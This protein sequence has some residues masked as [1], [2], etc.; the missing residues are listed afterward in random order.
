VIEGAFA[1]VVATLSFLVAM[2]IPLFAL[3]WRTLLIVIAVGAAFFA[4]LTLEVSVP[5][6]IPS[7]I[8]TF[9]GGLMLLGF[10]GGAIARFVSLLGKR[11]TTP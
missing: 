8:G 6:S 10:A 5:G 4:W 2:A 7:A 1:V 3:R 11:S 9:L